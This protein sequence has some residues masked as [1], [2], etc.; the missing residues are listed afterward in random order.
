VGA[1]VCFHSPLNFSFSFINVT[2]YVCKCLQSQLLG[3]LRQEITRL[4]PA[5]EVLRFDKI[6]SIQTYC[7]QTSKEKLEV[8]GDNQVTSLYFDKYKLKSTTITS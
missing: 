2:P 6:N 1:R 7:F 5:L 8:I 4:R 3:R